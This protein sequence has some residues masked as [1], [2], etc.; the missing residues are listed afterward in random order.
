MNYFDSLR[1]I[2]SQSGFSLAIIV[3]YAACIIFLIIKDGR[4]YFSIISLSILY[5][6][7][8]LIPPFGN[9]LLSKAG[10]EKYFK[11]FFVLPLIILLPLCLSLIFAENKNKKARVFIIAGIAV[12]L[13]STTGFSLNIFRFRGLNPYDRL[14]KGDD[15]KLIIAS[16]D[17]ISDDLPNDTEFIKCDDRT[18]GYFYDAVKAGADYLVLPVGDSR[19]T[20]VQYCGFSFVK[21]IGHERIY[22]YKDNY[23]NMWKVTQYASVTGNQAMIYS[24]TDLKGNLYL[25][26]GGWD[27]DADQVRQIIKDNGGKVTAWFLTHPHSDHINAFTTIMESGDVPEI[28]AVYA[29]EFDPEK[30]KEEAQDWDVY[31][32]FERFYHIMNDNPENKKLLHYLH[33]GDTLELQDFYVRVMHDYQSKIGGDA[34]NDGSLML[35]FKVAE[36]NDISNLTITHFNGQE[37]EHV[38]TPSHGSFLVCGDIGES[39]SQYIMDEYQSGLHSYILQV[40]HHGNGG[41]SQDLY[42]LVNAET[43][44]FD[45]PDWLFNPAPGTNYQ[46]DKNKLYFEN[47]GAVIYSYATAPNSVTM[48]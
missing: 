21:T 7:L 19:E 42:D 13:F 33:D 48:R 1:N 43:V 12:V 30:Y 3:V 47:K 29:S 28:D 39:Q 22:Q 11:L 2:F 26:D 9:L 5:F 40:S 24:I 37:A 34:A 46:T 8:L 15:G 18:N 14:S 4:K 25:I 27:A 35:Q 41:L 20:E 6:V 23:K 17:D 32:D 36:D 44:F 10:D 31:S 38:P 16:T 45:A